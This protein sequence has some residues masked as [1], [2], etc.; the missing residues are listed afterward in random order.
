VGRQCVP[1]LPAAFGPPSPMPLRCATLQDRQVG[2]MAPDRWDRLLRA[3]AQEFAQA[4]YEHA[5]LNR[6]IRAC[7]MSKSSFLPLRRF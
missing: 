3:A 7:G 1:A 4:G 5:S 6:V 2:V